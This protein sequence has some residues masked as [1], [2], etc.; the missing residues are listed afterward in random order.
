LVVAVFADG[1]SN[2]MRIAYPRAQASNPPQ[3]VAFC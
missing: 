3:A 2:G 1:D